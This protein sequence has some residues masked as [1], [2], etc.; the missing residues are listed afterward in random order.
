MMR[1][2]RLQAE[3]K[4]RYRFCLLSILWILSLFLGACA[5]DVNSVLPSAQTGGRPA[6]ETN[7]TIA[8]SG[9][10]GSGAVEG[11]TMEKGNN[12]TIYL[13]GGCFWGVEKYMS[14]IPGVV[15]TEVGYANGQTESPTYEDVCYN[16]TGHAETVLVEY[17][18]ERLELPFLLELFY[19]I[20]DPT[21]LNRQG[22]D[23]GTQYRT[24]IYYID[25]SDRNII[26]ESI[27]ELGGRTPGTIVIEVMPLENYYTAEEYHQKY[28][29]KNPYGY[30]HI[31][32]EEF[33]K[34]ENLTSGGESAYVPKDRGF[35]QIASFSTTDLNGNAITQSIFNE[36]PL[37]F[38]NYWATWCG[39]CRVELPDFQGMYEKYR[40]QVTFITIIDDGENNDNA[41]SL[42]GQ[43]LS[44]YINLL[45]TIELVRP[46]QSGY[47]PTSVIVDSGGYLLIDKI[48][49]AAGDYSE[50]ID[51]ALAI[52]GCID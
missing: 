6:D 32:S 35:G 30:C 7:E 37:T 23:A 21:S 1:N 38:I 41:Q 26:D 29:D 28:L 16:N 52:V 17:D 13:A 49:G 3:H 40:D 47:V 11:N 8:I 43:Y 15:R 22:N 45:P 33:E 5:G 19:E 50:Y 10:P 36:K 39:P 44:G 27:A 46:I 9:L 12:K 34:V 48:I 31:S 42:A 24:G 2:S 25:E 4:R 20:I 14:L 18:P 51:S